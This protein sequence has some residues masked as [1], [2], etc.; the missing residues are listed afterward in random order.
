MDLS[1]FVQ[2]LL[3][4]ISTKSR[5][6]LKEFEL[7]AVQGHT[8]SSI[9]VSVES[10]LTVSP[11]VFGDIDVFTARKWLVF[12]TC[13]VFDAPARRNLLEFLDET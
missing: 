12:P 7:I 11:T 5:E 9:L 8:R 6:I 13:P 1:S 3:A 10:A 4:P 2:L